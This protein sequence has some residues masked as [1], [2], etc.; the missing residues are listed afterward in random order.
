M[1]NERKHIII[2]EIKYWKQSK[3]L[4]DRYCDFL[5][6]LYSR[7]EEMNIEDVKATMSVLSDTK[8]KL[9]K[10]IMYLI[11][12]ATFC[13]VSLLVIDNYSA[14]VLG[15]SA[16][17]LLS[18]VVYALRP[19]AK[20]SGVI[21]L[22]NIA[23]AFILLAMSLRFWIMYFGGQVTVLIALLFINCALWLIMGKYLNIIYL[24]ISGVVGILL[25]VG[26]V[27]VQF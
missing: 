2:S 4:P 10:T 9:N 23:G 21:P 7:G 24:K 18:L 15:F 17:V 11:L 16:F 14:V 26:F 19:A 12:L 25:V 5:I 3:L 8:R 6:A 13:T 1:D 27:V 22:V 20:K